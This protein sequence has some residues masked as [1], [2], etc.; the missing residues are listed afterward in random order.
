MSNALTRVNNLTQS[1]LAKALHGENSA[2]ALLERI[3]A[4]RATVVASKKKVRI[5]MITF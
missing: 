5:Y 3:Q 1:M 2:E 4:E